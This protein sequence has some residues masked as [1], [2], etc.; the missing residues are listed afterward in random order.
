[1][2]TK[3]YFYSVRKLSVFFIFLFICF[4]AIAQKVTKVDL[5]SSD[6]FI[7]LK[8]N[9]EQTQKVIKPTFRQDNSILTCDSAYFYIEKNAFDA[10]GH[11][12][13][14]QADSLNIYS[15]FLNYNGN[16]KIATLTRNV[17][18]IDKDAVL[19]TNNLTYNMASRVG[20]YYNNGK[21]VNGENTLVSKNGYYF[22][23]SRDAYFRYNVVINSPDAVIKS[24]TMR[25]NTN[26]KIAYFYG[27]TNIYGKD[28]TLYTENGQY[29]TIL[30]QAKF[31]KKNL[32]TQGSK[33]LKGDSLF[34]DRKKGF[35]RAV[36]NILFKDTAQKIELRGDLGLYTKSDESITATK[37]AYLVLVT[38]KDS[39]TKDSLW[40]TADTLKSKVML[41][42]DLLLLQAQNRD[43]VKKGP[44]ADASKNKTSAKKTAPNSKNKATEKEPLKA[45]KSNKTD[46]TS[47]AKVIQQK[48]ID[49]LKNTKPDSMLA[50]VKPPDSL[51]TVDK[52]PAKADDKK[53]TKKQ[54]KKQERAA[55]KAAEQKQEIAAQNKPVVKPDAGKSSK[56][57]S[58]KNGVAKI[59]ETRAKKKLLK[60]SLAI[61]PGDTTKVRVVFAYRKVKI[62]K[63][64]LQSKSDSAFFSYGDSTIRIYRTPII[65]SQGSQ[66]TG[67][68]IYMQLKKKKLDNMDIYTKGMVVNVDE[69]DS[70]KYNQVG[71]KKMKGYFKDDKLDRIFVYGNAESIYYAKDSTGYT[72]MNRSISSRIRIEFAD[73]KAKNIN[74]IGKAELVFYPME[75]VTEENRIL[76]N[77]SWKPKERPKSKEEI[78]PTL[79]K[80]QPQKAKKPVVKPALTNKNNPKKPGLKKPVVKPLAKNQ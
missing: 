79:A 38:E 12:H 5:I 54:L 78:I 19:T 62:F 48:P 53:L 74:W 11:V 45:A 16:T 60:D 17:R 51:K 46:S 15:D 18:L 72:G 3:K 52:T 29:N 28:D 13:I 26:S 40:M 76:E 43:A 75:D 1:M 70:T 14:N 67:D 37:N 8:R 56:T 73:S 42:N 50:V 49:S 58:L 63:S 23:N 80:K 66:L 44:P 7:G 20:N 57:D 32:Y 34:Y 68:T 41:K 71:G 2:V 35:G 4:S 47:L 22:A 65:W 25:Y 9:G 27:P 6:S 33:S 69:K 55:K 39:V 77:F 61:K 59:S 30:G 24:D 36:K 31:G 10:F 64:D 21:I